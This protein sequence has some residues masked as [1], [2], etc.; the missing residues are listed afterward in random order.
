MTRAPAF[1][2]RPRPDWRARLL[3]PIGALYGAATA[4]R[5]ARGPREKLDVPIVCIGNI[6]AGGTGKTPTV[7]AVVERLRDRFHTPHIVSRG[8]G[9]TL[10]GPVRVDPARHKA[11]EVGDEPLLLA[12]FAEVWVARD[13]AAGAR[14]AAAVGA[15][16]IVLG[17]ILD[18]IIRVGDFVE[19]RTQARGLSKTPQMKRG[20]KGSLSHTRAR[21]SRMKSWLRRLYLASVGSSEKMVRP[22]NANVSALDGGH[23]ACLAEMSTIDLHAYTRTNQPKEAAYFNAT[24]VLPLGTNTYFRHSV[25]IWLHTCWNQSGF[26]CVA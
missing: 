9:G 10:E 21:L 22:T 20:G 25:G 15:S 6:N 2:H 26:G 7:M 19:L 13:R 16:V 3:Q 14:A 18:Y 1:W 12:A 4:R 5:L 23:A 24:T 11:S 8:Y 17:T